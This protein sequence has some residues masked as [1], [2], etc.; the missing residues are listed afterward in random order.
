MNF[1]PNSYKKY[2][3]AVATAFVAIA[4]PAQATDC[5]TLCQNAAAQAAQKAVNQ[6]EPGIV[7]QCAATVSYSNM[8]SCV[9]SQLGV[10]ANSTA[11]QV[12]AECTGSCR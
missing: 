11:Q 9:G 2:F 7:A 8:S 4:I 1:L 3:A 10:I 6:A 5:A 12:L